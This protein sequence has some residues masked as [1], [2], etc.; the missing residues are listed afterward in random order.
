M[1]AGIGN[2]ETTKF[3]ILNYFF[4]RTTMGTRHGVT[5]ETGQQGK[6]QVELVNQPV[7]IVTGVAGE[8]LHERGLF[9]ASLHAI[10]GE[11]FDI[12]GDLVIGLS[13]STCAVDT[14]RGFGG[15]TTTER[16][17]IE[18]DNASTEL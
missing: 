7:D 13:A 1:Q 16:R 14:R 18:K 6:I 15:V 12:I 10:L 3:I 5:T 9:G 4:Y 17:F 8:D 11:N 2:V